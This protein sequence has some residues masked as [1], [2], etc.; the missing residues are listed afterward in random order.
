MLNFVNTLIFPY[1]RRIFAKK[2]GTHKC[3]W[4]CCIFDKAATRPR[5]HAQVTKTEP[6]VNSQDVIS[7]TSGTN[8]GHSEHLYDI[9]IFEPFLVGLQRSRNRQPSWQ[10]VTNS[11]N[12]KIQDCGGRHIKFRK[13]VKIIRL[14]EGI[15]TT[16]VGQN[17]ASRPY[18]DDRRYSTLSTT[19]R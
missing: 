6:E 17:D 14:S 11:V 15:S 18:G 8:V 7:W 19:A 2:N 1:W 5:I 12:Y 16:F 9:G 13:N 4:S 3:A 10:N